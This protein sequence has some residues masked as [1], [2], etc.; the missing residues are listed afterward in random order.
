MEHGPPNPVK[1]DSMGTGAK[2]RCACKFIKDLQD[3]SVHHFDVLSF[4]DCAIGIRNG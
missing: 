3:G 2:K 4:T 1:I